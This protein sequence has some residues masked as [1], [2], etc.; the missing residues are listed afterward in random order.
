MSRLFF[1]LLPAPETQRRMASLRPE[2]IA[3]RAVREGNLHATLAF[4]GECSP[5]ETR[6]ALSILNASKFQPFPLK[7]NRFG[8]WKKPQVLW[9][10]SDET[11]EALTAFAE[12]L[13]ARLT[14][15]GFHP[16][17]RPFALH[18]TLARKFHG[19]PPVWNAAPLEWQADTV[20]LMESLSSPRGVIYRALAKRKAGN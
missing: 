6:T 2:N 17:L 12:D 8:F 20:A 3:G 18:I 10:G 19:E 13:K 5:T 4:L 14:A 15:S 9:L 7:L 11:P 16:D 1:A